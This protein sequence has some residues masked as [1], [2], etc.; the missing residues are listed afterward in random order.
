MGHAGRQPVKIFEVGGHLP[1][2]GRLCFFVGH[3]LGRIGPDTVEEPLPGLS[4]QLECGRH[5]NVGQNMG[6]IFQPQPIVHQPVGARL[7][8][9]CVKEGLMALFPQAGAKLGQQAGDRQP[10]LQR[11]L[12]KEPKGH[13]DLCRSNDFPIREAVMHL[14]KLQFDQPHRVFGRAAQGRA[15]AILDEFAKALKVKELLDSA[16]IVVRRHQLGK[17]QLVDLRRFHVIVV[18]QHDSPPRHMGGC[19]LHSPAPLRQ[20]LST[21]KRG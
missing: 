15:V 10:A 11:H 17:D 8:D 18:F 6:G 1:E 9:H 19:M 14:Q 20:F 16:Q 2:P 7:R 21:L 5:R 13:I 12:Q 4:H 3:L